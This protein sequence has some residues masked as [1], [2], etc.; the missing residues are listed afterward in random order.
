MKL[1]KFLYKNK[2]LLQSSLSKERFIASLLTDVFVIVAIV[3]AY[4]IFLIPIVEVMAGFESLSQEMAPEEALAAV[5]GVATQMILLFTGYVLLVSV[6]SISSRLFI[7]RKLSNA[8]YRSEK[9]A[10]KLLRYMKHF[11]G[12][13]LIS[14]SILIVPLLI[15]FLSVLRVENMAHYP[16]RV[17]ALSVMSL[18]FILLLAHL[19]T[20]FNYAFARSSKITHSYKAAFQVGL[21]NIHY[22][23][24]P[25]LVLFLVVYVV[26]FISGFLLRGL[27]SFLVQVIVYLALLSVLRLYMSRLIAVLYKKNYKG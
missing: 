3:L 12:T 27:F 22:F 21:S 10:R 2:V 14:I 8:V 7:W 1:S 6:S 20:N 5:G 13:L 18:A 4:F 16:E 24:L 19:L 15:G 17:L 26:D 23:I 9:I 11:A 25:Y